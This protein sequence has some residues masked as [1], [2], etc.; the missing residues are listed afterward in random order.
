MS[1]EYDKLL[2]VTLS[3]YYSKTVKQAFILMLAFKVTTVEPYILQCGHS[4]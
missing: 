3:L 4:P 2:G 1:E